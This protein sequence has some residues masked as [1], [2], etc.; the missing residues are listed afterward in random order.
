MRM[1]SRIKDRTKEKMLMDH[2]RRSHK[3]K[4]TMDR[5]KLLNYQLKI[6]FINK[7]RL[8]LPPFLTRIMK[9]IL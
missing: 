1:M 5:N 4:C 2:D 3:K 8:R 6:K 7:R 9:M